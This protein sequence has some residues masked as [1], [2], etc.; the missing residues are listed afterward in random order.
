MNNYRLEIEQL[1]LNTILQQDK[2]H[3]LDKI[4][5]DDYELDYTL[6]KANRTNRLVA[7]AIWVLHQNGT[8]VSDITVDNFISTREA[9]NGLEFLDLTSK[10]WVSFETMLKYIKHLQNIN[11]EEKQIEMLKAI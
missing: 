2:S 1:I 6:F 4:E 5:L 7:K 9:L 10:L 8:P 3:D 11:F